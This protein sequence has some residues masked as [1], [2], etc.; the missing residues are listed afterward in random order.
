M[1]LNQ[2]SLLYVLF[3]ECICQHSNH[4]TALDEVIKIHIEFVLAVKHSR[5]QAG[6]VRRPAKQK[7]M[8]I[9]QHTH[10]TQILLRWESTQQ[11]QKQTTVNSGP[12]LAPL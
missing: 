6:E 11:P 9:I 1:N 8:S 4:H 2:A 10:T 12:F 7:T 3:L 5:A